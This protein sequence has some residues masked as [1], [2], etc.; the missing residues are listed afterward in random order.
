MEATSIAIDESTD[1]QDV[2]QCS[3]FVRY[4]TNEFSV[5]EELLHLLLLL[6]TT[7]GLSIWHS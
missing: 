7:R 1:I 6:G 3:I 2:V 4:V 5:E